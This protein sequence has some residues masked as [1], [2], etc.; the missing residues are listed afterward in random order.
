MTP[1][2]YTL[3]FI[4]ATHAHANVLS[5]DRL[6]PL[7]VFQLSHPIFSDDQRHIRL[8]LVRQF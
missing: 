4:Y 6:V 5:M 7:P 1:S 8:L 3:K 2:E